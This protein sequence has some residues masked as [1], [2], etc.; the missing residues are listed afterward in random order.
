[1][2][3]LENVRLEEIRNRVG[4]LAI[5]TQSSEP[6]SYRK[7]IPNFVGGIND[8]HREGYVE[9]IGIGGERSY[10]L[11]SEGW[12]YAARFLESARRIL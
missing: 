10:E 5:L 1:M 4:A 9:S 3:A 7:F 12:Y 8:L 2:S 11:T 6:I